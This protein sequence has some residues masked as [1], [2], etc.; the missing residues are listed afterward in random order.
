[1]TSGA[2]NGTVPLTVDSVVKA[3]FSIIREDPTSQILRSKLSS[4]CKRIFSGLIS[5]WA[6]FFDYKNWNPESS[7]FTALSK[8]FKGILCSSACLY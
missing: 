5:Q 7:V 1:M 8:D 2:R 3:D 4:L 6:M